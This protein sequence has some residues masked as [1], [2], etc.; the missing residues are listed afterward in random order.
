MKLLAILL[1]L[2]ACATVPLEEPPQFPGCTELEGEYTCPELDIDTTGTYEQNIVIRSPAKYSGLDYPVLEYYVSYTYGG[3][4]SYV[5]NDCLQ[6]CL[7]H[8]F[9]AYTGVYMYLDTKDDFD[10]LFLPI[11]SQDE[12]LS[13]VLATKNVLSEKEAEEWLRK[14]LKPK[15]GIKDTGFIITYYDTEGGICCGT[16]YEFFENSYWIDRQGEISFISREKVGTVKNRAI[17]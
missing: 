16:D 11:E 10:N 6:I 17:A 8:R 1:L 15:A 3:N 2:T 4:I 7:A 12:A 14:D 13:Y 9:I 5:K